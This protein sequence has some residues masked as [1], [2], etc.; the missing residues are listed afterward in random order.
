MLA[1]LL[2]VLEAEAADE[3]ADEA[4]DEEADEA[5]DEEADEA[6][7]EEADAAASSENNSQYLYALIKVRF[8]IPVVPVALAALEALSAAF[9][10]LI[11]VQTSV[12]VVLLVRV[13]SFTLAAEASA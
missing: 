3:E 6:A 13:S 9:E 12:K 11:L 2:G 1:P 7:D 5:A 10:A 8:H 4:A